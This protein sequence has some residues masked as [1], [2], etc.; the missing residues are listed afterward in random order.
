MKLK[1]II[2]DM[3]DLKFK[4]LIYGSIVKSK[5]KLVIGNNVK[6]KKTKII[7]PKGSTVKIG[8]NSTFFNVNL[9][10]RGNVDIGESNIFES[11]TRNSRVEIIGV[12]DLII[13][14][15]NRLRSKV[16]IRYNGMLQMDDHN[17]INEGSEIRCDENIVI[18]SYNQISYNCMIWDTN[19]HNIYP[20]KE[21]RRLTKDNYPIFGF[22]YEK[23]KT[24]PVK[25]GNDCWIGKDVA[26]LK[27][28]RIG[29][30]CIIA[31][32]TVL[33]NVAVQDNFT[34][35]NDFKTTSIHN[36]I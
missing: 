13:G 35:F 1:K 12:G 23:P 33:N 25:I 30:R 28:T 10:I 4:Y 19:T 29:N 8:D 22:E 16:W 24:I 34:V 2:N 17:N 6:I 20:C 26:L 15:Y 7:V 21:R 5:G 14:S 18:G 9:T 31:F 11:G 32:R 3:L 27:G 36:N